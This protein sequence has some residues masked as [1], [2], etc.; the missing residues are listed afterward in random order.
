[1]LEPVKWCYYKHSRDGSHDIVKARTHIDA[2]AFILFNH[3]QNFMRLAVEHPYG[4]QQH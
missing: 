4:P 1:M 2:P 3:T